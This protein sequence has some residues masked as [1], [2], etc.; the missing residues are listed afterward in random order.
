MLLS[1]E[2]L[3]SDIVEESMSENAAEPMTDG[4]S[5]RCPPLRLPNG[6]VFQLCPCYH[7]L[8]FRQ[9]HILIKINIVGKVETD[10]RHE[11][12]L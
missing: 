1:G 6:D 10:Q 9:T 3:H 5:L 11:L 8:M 2:A 4:H 12:L 7:L